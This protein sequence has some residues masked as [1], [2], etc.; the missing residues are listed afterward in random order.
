MRISF[1]TGLSFSGE[2]SAVEFDSD[3]RGVAQCPRLAKASPVPRR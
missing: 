2:V 3:G 1:D